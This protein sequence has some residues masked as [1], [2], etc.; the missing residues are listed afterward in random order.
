PNHRVH[1]VT[2]GTGS[3]EERGDAATCDRVSVRGRGGWGPGCLSPHVR[4]AREVRRLTSGDTVV[5]CSRGL[6]EGLSAAL[7]GR[8]FLCWTHGEELGYASTSKELSW[9]RRRVYRRAAA[10]VANSRNS[11][12]LLA[13]WGVEG[14]RITVIHPCVD[15]ER[16]RPD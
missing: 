12:R 9:L 16:F 3:R 15:V 10:I 7:S 4:V 2:D 8:R 11:A 5:H 13:E 6:P 1:V 14:N